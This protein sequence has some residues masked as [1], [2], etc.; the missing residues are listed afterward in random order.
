MS[1]ILIA[2]GVLGGLG[3]LFGV[4]LGGASIAFAVKK[5][6]RI[7]KVRELLPGAN[8]G[9]CGY[10]GCD[11]FAA[12]VVTGEAKPGGCPVNSVEQTAKIGELLG[13][14]VANAERVSAMVYCRG[15]HGVADE[16]YRYYGIE[17]C[18]AASRLAGGAKECP[19][20]CLGLGSCMRACKF[21]AI[22]IKDGIALIDPDK[23]TACGM[24][25]K[26]CPKK[27]IGFVPYDSKYVVACHSKDKGNVVSKV[28]RAGCIGCRICEKACPV[29]AIHVQDNLA[30]I[31]YKKCIGCGECA[32][33]C[34]RG[35]IVER[36]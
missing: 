22:T 30:Q 4:V 16:K 2:L 33:K 26:T 21:G 10:A 20:S 3:L 5:D 32:L 17:D 7:D 13:V 25:I 24:C 23:C 11:N 15:T 12:A 1:Q 6:G 34:P 9:G 31:D 27:V 36:K 35:I 28:C 29:D 18:L 19:Y 8:C 14:S